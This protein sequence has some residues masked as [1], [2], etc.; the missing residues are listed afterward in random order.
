MRLYDR[1]MIDRTGKYIVF[2][3]NYEYLQDLVRHVPE[4]FGKVDP[5]SH[6]YSVYSDD[7]ETNRAFQSSKED[8]CDHLKLPFSIDMLNEVIHMDDI[9]GVILFRPAVSIM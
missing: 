1:H 6:I 9:G 2:C 5:N 7:P 3:A 4:G 8:D